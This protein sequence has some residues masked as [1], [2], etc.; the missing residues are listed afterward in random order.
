MV[1][2]EQD[3]DGG[4]IAIVR[5]LPGCVSEGDTRDEVMTNIRKAADLY[6]EHR[7]AAG[8]PVPTEAG[9]E[10]FELEPSARE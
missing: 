5:A 1:A 10:Y 6:I 9:R 2:L 7:I 3:A 4:Y 8:D